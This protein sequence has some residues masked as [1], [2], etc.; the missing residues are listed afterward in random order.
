MGSL[1]LPFA[2]AASFGWCYY[3]NSCLVEGSRHF[4]D[5]VQGKEGKDEAEQEKRKKYFNNQI[6]LE[7]LSRCFG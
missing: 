2:L 7:V 1:V 3:R 4:V 6:H 5:V